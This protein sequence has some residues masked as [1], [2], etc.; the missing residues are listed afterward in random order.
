MPNPNPS[1]IAVQVAAGSGVLV[2]NVYGRSMVILGESSAQAL[3]PGWVVMPL[4]GGFVSE[5][6][7][8]TYYYSV[9]ILGSAGRGIVG[10]FVVLK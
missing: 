8:G 7:N 4:P 2:L 6:S 10:K 9:K 1:G 3:G 5:A